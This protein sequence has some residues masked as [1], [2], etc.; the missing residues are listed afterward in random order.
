[1]KVLLVF[2]MVC[3]E[4]IVCLPIDSRS[5]PHNNT[6][7]IK[8]DQDR[9]IK[10]VA[11]F[12][13]SN[14]LETGSE[15]EIQTIRDYLEQLKTDIRGGAESYV[16]DSVAMME[17]LT[18]AIKNL[19]KK[20]ESTVDRVNSKSE[21][22]LLAIKAIEEL[23]GFG[24]QDVSLIEGQSEIIGSG[25]SLIETGS[26]QEIQTIKDYLEQ[27]KTDIRGGASSYVQDSVSMME[28]LTTAIKNLK[29]KIESTVDRVNSKAE[30][31]L[32][33]VKAIEELIGFGGTH[34]NFVEQ[35]VEEESDPQSDP[36]ETEET[37]ETPT[38]EED[39]VVYSEAADSS[40]EEEFLELDSPASPSEEKLL[41]TQNSTA[42][43]D[44][45]K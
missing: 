7:K 43:A 24:G 26:V 4:F 8:E 40:P 31:K 32:L 6:T 14:L 42:S 10:T 20:I 19:K 38:E 33:A 34:E 30:S 22:K 35:E 29:A 36:E 27:L 37:E 25:H 3:V 12:L 39:K 18:T 11:D 2:M 44:T 13:E 15:Q 17:E 9:D 45:K 28:E 1:M 41:L 16:Q 21:S 23:I 5:T